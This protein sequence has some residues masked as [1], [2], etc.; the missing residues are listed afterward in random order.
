MLTYKYKSLYLSVECLWLTVIIIRPGFKELT[1]F[2]I[3]F[4]FSSSKEF[5]Y[6][7]NTKIFVSL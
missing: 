1:S 6:S 4:S 7:S 5:V 2:I 3:F